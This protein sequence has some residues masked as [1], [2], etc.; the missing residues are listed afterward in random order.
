[1]RY[2]SEKRLR[3]I[4]KEGKDHNFTISNAAA[5]GAI[6]AIAMLIY[7]ECENLPNERLRPM[8]DA[9]LD[10]PVLV[11]TGKGLREAFVS[12]HGDEIMVIFSDCSLANSKAFGWRPI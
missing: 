10:V 1:M 8:S 3:E 12:R 5:N 9:P 7:R 6:T 2:V 4:L 11:D